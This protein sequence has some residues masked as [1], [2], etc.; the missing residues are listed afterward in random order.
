MENHN[1]KPE[2]ITKPIQLLAVW[3][4]GLILIVSALLTAAGTIDQPSWLPAFFS[5]SAVSIIPLFLALI[6]LLQTRFR[7]QMQED[8][9]YSKFLNTNTLEV[10]GNQENEFFIESMTGKIDEKFI[11][12]ST[13]TKD[14]IVLLQGTISELGLRIPN[15]TIIEQ[16]K[17]FDTFDK[18]IKNAKKNI[19]VNLKLKNIDSVLSLL[20]ESN[21]KISNFFGKNDDNDEP[22]L[23]II[24]F[25]R[26][27]ELETLKSVVKILVPLG[28]THL[29]TTV[30]KNILYIGA[31]TYKTK[32]IAILDFEMLEVIESANSTSDIFNQVELKMKKNITSK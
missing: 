28:L 11:E 15:N 12:L 4:I 8:E 24:T 5:I 19:S 22:D 32:P 14:Q 2:K 17:E 30:S 7:P 27:V 23:F 16:K 25:G 18:F 29:A 9:Y 1:I 13:I 3:L 10:I 31:Y 6:F 20:M 26:D 21:I